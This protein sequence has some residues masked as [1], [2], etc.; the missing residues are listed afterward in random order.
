MDYYLSLFNECVVIISTY[1]LIPFSDAYESTIEFKNEVGWFFVGLISFQIVL[2]LIIPVIKG[3]I[4]VHGL[5]MKKLRIP[6]SEEKIV[7]TLIRGKPQKKNQL[8]TRI[9]APKVQKKIETQKKN[10]KSHQVSA[11]KTALN[12]NDSLHAPIQE[13]SQLPFES[14]DQIYEEQ[15]FNPLR[16]PI[17]HM[18][19]L[20]DA[21]TQLFD[22]I[23]N[24]GSHTHKLLQQYTSIEESESGSQ[25]Y[26][27]Y[28]QQKQLLEPYVIRLPLSQEIDEKQEQEDKQQAAQKMLAEREGYIDYEL[29]NDD[30]ISNDQ[31]TVISRPVD[32]A[33]EIELRMADIEENEIKIMEAE[34]K[35]QNKPIYLRM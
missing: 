4:I 20:T 24:K 5:V 16:G 9:M 12:H 11:S 31:V 21:R 19:Y 32:P 27:R 22:A 33:Q 34:R 15:V 30:P 13:I 2:N 35:Q 8:K 6:Q 14:S 29:P 23:Q 28:L 7:H 25:K 10:H 18:D 1:L 3:A 26:E 17:T